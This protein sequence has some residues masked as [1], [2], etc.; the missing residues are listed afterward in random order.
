LIYCD[1]ESC[2]ITTQSNG[3]FINSLFDINICKNSIC[4]LVEIK[5]QCSNHNYEV[6]NYNGYNYFCVNNAKYSFSKTNQYLEVSN[7]KASSIFPNIEYGNDKILVKID[8]YS[9]TQ[10]ITD[11]NGNILI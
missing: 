8:E 9:V 3:Y 1:T 10:Y 4:Q 2:E 11:S 5:G 7:I 6:T